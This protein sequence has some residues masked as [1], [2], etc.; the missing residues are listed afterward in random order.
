MLRTILKWGEFST[1]FFA[2][3]IS[4]SWKHLVI[5]MTT[6]T[7]HLYAILSYVWDYRTGTH[8]R[9]HTIQCNATLQH[10]ASDFWNFVYVLEQAASLRN[11]FDEEIKDILL[12]KKLFVGTFQKRTI[13]TVWNFETMYG[14]WVI[15]ASRNSVE[16]S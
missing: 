8:P 15:H 16:I 6:T 12:R 11:H 13:T 4:F 9:E 5:A 14:C 2:F 1:W 3:G 7:L 10:F